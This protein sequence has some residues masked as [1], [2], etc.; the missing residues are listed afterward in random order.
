MSE[1]VRMDRPF[2]AVMKR[3]QEYENAKT[4]QLPLWPEP[5]RG[6]PNEFSRSALF[7]AV[8]ATDNRYLDNEPIASQEGFTVTYTG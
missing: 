5:E 2:Q 8:E 7:A 3:H 1:V 4:L 6:V